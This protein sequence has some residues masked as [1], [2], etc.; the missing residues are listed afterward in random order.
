MADEQG[1]FL[2][3]LVEVAKCKFTDTPTLE[4]KQE[5]ADDIMRQM[6]QTMHHN[7]SYA[8]TLIKGERSKVLAEWNAEFRKRYKK[9]HS[10][11]TCHVTEAQMTRKEQSDSA[12]QAEEL[13]RATEL[14]QE[15]QRSIS[16]AQT[17]AQEF[18]DDCK[19]SLMRHLGRLK[20]V[21]KLPT[22]E[23]HRHPAATRA[24]IARKNA[25]GPRPSGITERSDMPAGT[26]HRV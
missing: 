21:Y 26:D 17:A 11:A 18:E 16:V 3:P 12:S 5:D 2:G 22:P 6:A 15:A 7:I 19:R 8:A 9:I 23:G 25:R 10:D 14:C 1:V 13:D 4:S 20:D 24:Y